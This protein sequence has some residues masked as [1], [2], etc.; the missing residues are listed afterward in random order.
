MIRTSKRNNVVLG[1]Y[2]HSIIAQL[3]KGLAE[4]DLVVGVCK[5]EIIRTIR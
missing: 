5:T 4:R 3:S 2:E 1:A